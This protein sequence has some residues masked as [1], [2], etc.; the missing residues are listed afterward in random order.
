[1]YLPTSSIRT[2]ICSAEK[3]TRSRSWCGSAREEVMRRWIDVQR[4]FPDETNGRIKRAV[5]FPPMPRQKTQFEPPSTDMG[6][7]FPSSAKF[8][9]HDLLCSLH[10]VL[11]KEWTGLSACLRARCLYSMISH[12]RCTPILFILIAWVP[13]MV[14]RVKMA[15]LAVHFCRASTHYFKTIEAAVRDRWSLTSVVCFLAAF[16]KPHT[17]QMTVTSFAI[18]TADS[19]QGFKG[20]C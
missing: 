9:C 14:C 3:R 8:L 16:Q 17:P 6:G 7:P 12:G 13:T 10:G 2:A 4:T 1:M 5:D 20:I 11:E 19:S 18:A 15:R